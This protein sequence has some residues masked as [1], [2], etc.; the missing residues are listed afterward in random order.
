MDRASIQNLSDLF[1]ISKYL[2]FIDLSLM[3][4]GDKGVEIL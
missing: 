2:A 4:L 3:S 1:S